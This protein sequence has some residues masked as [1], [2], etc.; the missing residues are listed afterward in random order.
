MTR[1]EKINLY[2][3]LNMYKEELETDS[4]QYS[5]CKTKFDFAVQTM[6]SNHKKTIEEIMNILV[7]DF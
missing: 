7:F 5:E 4:K 6:I 2:E 3:L 1:E